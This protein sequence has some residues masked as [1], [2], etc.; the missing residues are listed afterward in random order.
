MEIQPN[1]DYNKIIQEFEKAQENKPQ[2]PTEKL[3]EK[4][5]NNMLEEAKSMKPTQALLFI[6]TVGTRLSNDA[7]TVEMGGTLSQSEM[8]YIENLAK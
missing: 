7:Q 8:E 2:T 1:I 3:I 5:Y 4:A 6:T